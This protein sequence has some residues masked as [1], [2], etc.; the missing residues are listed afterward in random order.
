[1]FHFNAFDA[2][3]TKS[4]PGHPLGKYS[5]VNTAVVDWKTTGDPVTYTDE[6]EGEGVIHIR[7]PTEQSDLRFQHR[8]PIDS[9]NTWTDMVKYMQS[10]LEANPDIK[11]KLR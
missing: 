3:T 5:G 9:N 7:V 1:M 4:R 6:I 11:V 10:A 2:S 8:E